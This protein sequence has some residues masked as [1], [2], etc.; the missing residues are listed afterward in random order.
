MESIRNNIL[1]TQGPATTF[2][3]LRHGK[4]SSRCIAEPEYTKA[5]QTLCD[6]GFGRYVEF[7]VPRT[8]APCKVFIKSLPQQWPEGSNISKHDFEDA[9]RKPVHKYI[10]QAMRNY[11][12]EHGHL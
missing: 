9:M 8:T 5:V 7:T 2:R 6:D 11:L 10:T 4:R 12:V 3:V 1:M